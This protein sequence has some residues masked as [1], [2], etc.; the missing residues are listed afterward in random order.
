M[1]Q[2]S[3]KA[4]RCAAK[5]KSAEHSLIS[6]PTFGLLKGT[7]GVKDFAVGAAAGLLGQGGVKWLAG[8]LG[9][10]PSIPQV[11]QRF[12]P[13]TSGV[14][15]G[16]GLYYL[17]KKV[18][19]KGKG[20]AYMTGAIAAGATLQAWQELQAM[21][22]ATFNDYIYV[23]TY[24]GYNGVLIDRPLA[25]VLIDRPSNTSAQNLS[26]LQAINMA[27]RDEDAI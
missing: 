3:G 17:D 1:K 18:L 6:V 9:I 27:G 14:V 8:Q 16:L 22:P 4:R 15:T 21:Y 2:A 25:G 13:L 7:V 10:L 11:V 19:R 20:K 23:P 5:R 24:A 12:M 26:R